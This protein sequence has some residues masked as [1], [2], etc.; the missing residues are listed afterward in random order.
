MSGKFF[1]EYIERIS[2][3]RINKMLTDL[4]VHEE[5]TENGLIGDFVPGMVPQKL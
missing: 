3:E 4:T 5:V 2:I 1:V